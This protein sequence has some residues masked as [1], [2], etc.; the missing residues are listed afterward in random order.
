MGLTKKQKRWVADPSEAAYKTTWGLIRIA[1]LGTGLSVDFKA[2]IRRFTDDFN[3]GF[4]TVQ[5]PNQRTPIANQSTPHRSMILE[6][7]VPA[8]SDAEAA[9]N[10]QKC[11][12]LANMTLPLKDYKAGYNQHYPKSSFVSIKFANLIQAPNGGPLPGWI[13][14]FTFSPNFDQGTFISNADTTAYD[15]F[16]DDTAFYGHYMPKIIDISLK[17]TPFMSAGKGSPGYDVDKKEWE[18]EHFPYDVKFPPKSWFTSE[19]H[20]GTVA[21]GSTLDK[22]LKGL[23]K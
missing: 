1:Q 8:A 6:W 11:S 19:A 7:F 9:I 5:Y 3:A 21:V 15:T 13:D 12:A 23:V 14:G 10:L 17:F 22:Y 20:D 2:F 18:V 16:P 4:K